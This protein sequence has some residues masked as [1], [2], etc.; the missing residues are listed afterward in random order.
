[1]GD[2]EMTDDQIDMVMNLYKILN[3]SDS[4]HFN[5]IRSLLNTAAEEIRV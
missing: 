4:V 5:S 3:H 1:M 2:Q